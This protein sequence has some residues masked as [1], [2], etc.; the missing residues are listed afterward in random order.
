MLGRIGIADRGM[1]SADNLAWLRET[2]RRFISG[3][4]QSELKK[5]GSGR[6]LPEGWRAVH[7]GVEVRLTRRPE[8]DETVILCRS[9]D[10]RSN[11]R[12]MHDKFSRRIEDALERLSAR[13]A[14]QRNVSTRC[15]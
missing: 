6:A 13:I 12:A 3:A 4:P 11:E 1:A 2:G 15:Q 14:A 9:A 5:F 8:T 10:R 7:E